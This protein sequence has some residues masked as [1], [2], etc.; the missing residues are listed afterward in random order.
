MPVVSINSFSA[1]LDL[2]L[3]EELQLSEQLLQLITQEKTLLDFLPEPDAET[4]IRFKASL[5][6][7]LEEL[8]N[9]R[10]HLMLTAGFD[11]TPEGVKE[12]LTVYAHVPALAQKFRQLT[13]VAR[14]CH[15]ANQLLG[16]VLNRKTGFFSRLLHQLASAGQAPGLYQANGQKDAPSSL[17][18]RLSI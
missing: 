17:H 1:T 16:Q 15:A 5:L 3:M 8:S 7:N 2:L 18:R 14:K 4:S 12:C 9:K 11:N 13:E 6:R 10:A